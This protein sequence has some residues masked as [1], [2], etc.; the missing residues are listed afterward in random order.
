MTSTC[1][2]YNNIHSVGSRYRVY[3]NVLLFE[4]LKLKCGK[5]FPVEKPLAAVKIIIL[6]QIF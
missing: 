6:L 3:Y 2:N 4:I 1:Q 5:Y